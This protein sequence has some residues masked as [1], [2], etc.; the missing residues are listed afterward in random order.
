[1]DLSTVIG[2]F[3]G[4]TLILVSIMFQGS[5]LTF[6]SLSSLLIVIG[7]TI[8]A[9][10]IS[11]PM[12]K[13]VGVTTYL[14]IAF[15]DISHEPLRVILDIIKMAETARREGLLALENEVED[16]QDEFL[17]KGVQLIVDG[18][19]P[20]LT[21]N[22]LETEILMM[23]ERH[24]NSA[25]IFSF[26]GASAPAFGMLGTLIGLIMMLKNLNDPS[27]LGPAMA[28]ALITTFYGSFFA[29]LFCI[30]IAGKLKIKSR[31]EALVKEIIIEGILSIQAGENPRIVAEKMKSFLYA[32]QKQ[33]LDE[34]RKRGKKNE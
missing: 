34:E 1:M 22:I 23:E 3:S 26:M 16:S 32:E 33:E 24:K 8:C 31:E 27:S 29:N 21:R 28:V 17:K 25:G 18:T 30:P 15:K 5:I 20:D 11:Y 2:M 14:K 4:V 10:L 12:S 9:T 19:D 6:W 13:F 7:G